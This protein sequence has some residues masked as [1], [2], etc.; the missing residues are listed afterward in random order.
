MQL[1]LA[2]AGATQLF[3]GHTV[4]GSLYCGRRRW[5]RL[6]AH[7]RTLRAASIGGAETTREFADL[8]SV[9]LETLRTWDSGRRLIPLHLLQQA[10]VAVMEHARN[11]ELLSLDHLAC[12]FGVHERTLRDA[13]GPGTGGEP[14]GL[15]AVTTRASTHA[16]R[17]SYERA[18]DASVLYTGFGWRSFA[19]VSH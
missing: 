19:H 3:T 13:P 9:P 14:A 17:R 7:V 12:E 4:P 5:H 11:T 2:F 18:R 16:P 6:R 1:A 10:K 8:L 15:D